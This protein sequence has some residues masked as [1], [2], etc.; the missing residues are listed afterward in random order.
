VF[1]GVLSITRAKL[2]QELVSLPLDLEQLV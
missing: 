2:S 1:D